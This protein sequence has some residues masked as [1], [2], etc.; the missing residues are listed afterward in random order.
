MSSKKAKKQAKSLPEYQV[1]NALVNYYLVLMFTVFPLFFTHKYTNIRHDKLNLFL[2]LSCSL[3]VAE[4]IVL[5]LTSKQRKKGKS[6]PREKW[7]NQLSL[8]DYAFGAMVLLYVLSTLLSD[9]PADS[10]TGAQGRNN[11]LFL[12]IV[13]FLIYIV[14]S[15]LF[16]FKEYVF[17]L[18]AAASMVVYILC[19]LNF[20]GVDPLGMYVGYSE[21]VIADFT[22]TI[23]NKNIMSCFCCLS[24]PLFVMMY[25]DNA[26][27][28]TRNLYLS[29]SGLGFAAM[30]CA[31][32]ESGFLGIVPTMAIILLYSVR[33]LY[34]L[35]RFFSAAAAMLFWS[36]VLWIF[37][38]IS[39]GSQK[40]LGTIQR[41]LICD[42][43]TLIALICVGIIAAL[44]HY[45]CMI[46]A[47]A[48]LP[49][50]VFYALLGVYGAVVIVAVSMLVYYTFIDTETKLGAVTRYFRFDEKWGTHRGYMWIKS[51][52][53][54]TT[55]DFKNILLGCGPDT[56]YNAFRP[57]FSE[58][59][60]RFGDSATN[61]AH[62]E[63]LNYL[64]TTGVLG[65]GAYLTVFGSA[66]VNVF[67]K[68]EKNALAFMF[69]I[70]VVCYLIQ[71]TVNLATPITT[72]LLFVFL[73]LSQAALRKT[74]N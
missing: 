66:I 47:G 41:V 48:R 27:F 34:R 16:K 74:E 46:D 4:V 69:I 32:S 12:L 39:G 19:I 15:R 18:F 73:A 51:W 49:K 56:F 58:L 53:I 28:L 72:P 14:I 42:Y 37:M 7:Y 67:R 63:F 62:N 45:L 9:R 65:L 33:V 26:N 70:P 24:V 50:A 43:R 40:D 17:A 30:L 35:R 8:T 38:L 68:A 11:G 36:K 3:V 1:K 59:S 23:G 54:F 71:S 6:L 31:D 22:S 13:Y 20:F 57:Y 2:V 21:K 61:C 52:E 5:I 44:L 29:A 60:E 10:F 64:I 55:S 25:M